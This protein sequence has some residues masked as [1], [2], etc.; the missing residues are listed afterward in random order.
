MAEGEAGSISLVAVE[1]VL[2]AELLEQVEREALLALAAEAD[3]QV[4][5]DKLA[6]M[7]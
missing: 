5:L 4:K 3:N 7:A 2:E 1:A 6:K